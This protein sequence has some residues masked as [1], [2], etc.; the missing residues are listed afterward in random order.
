MGKVPVFMEFTSL[1]VEGKSEFIT[2]HNQYVRSH[3]QGRE[4]MA[5]C[6]HLKGLAFMGDG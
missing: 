2:Q 4:R 3:R 5:V 1:V 6:T